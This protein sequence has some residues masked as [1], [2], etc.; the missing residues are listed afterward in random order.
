MLT[1][2]LSNSNS[3][4]RARDRTGMLSI[5]WGEQKKASLRQIIN[6]SKNLFTVRPFFDV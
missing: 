5:K 2:N 3:G 6:F 1:P 4:S